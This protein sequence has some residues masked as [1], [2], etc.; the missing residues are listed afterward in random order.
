MEQALKISPRNPGEGLASYCYRILYNNIMNLRLPP[1][2]IINE[3]EI[4]AA[5]GVTRTPVHEAM[6]RLKEET[7]I[8]ILPR[9]ESR[10]SRISLPQVCEGVF[11]RTSLEPRVVQLI[12]G[13]V[14]DELK[15]QMQKSLDKQL[16]ILESGQNTSEFYIYDRAFHEMLFKAAGK[17]YVYEL[18]WMINLH[19]L[20][21]SYLID[22]DRS[23]FEAVE[24]SSLEEHQML[25]D[26][27][28]EKRPLDFDLNQ[29]MYLHITRFQRYVEPYVEHYPD[30]FTFVEESC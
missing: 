25:F 6:S 12:I 14:S 18:S 1:N 4:A 23:Y 22:F 30:F 10:V 7:L 29:Y 16:E 24:Y 8:E 28:T 13:K 20:R 9:K 3:A 15:Q 2:S 11:T 26:I 19:S 27:I 17:E 21:V 5:L